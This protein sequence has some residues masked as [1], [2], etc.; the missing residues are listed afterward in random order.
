MT[1]KRIL[2]N[3]IRWNLECLLKRADMCG[4]RVI[5]DMCFDVKRE[6]RHSWTI[7]GLL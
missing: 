6:T 5:L 3:S 7:K 4:R 1:R 2:Y